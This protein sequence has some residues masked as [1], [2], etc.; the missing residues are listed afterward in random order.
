MKKTSLLT[1]LTA[2]ILAGCTPMPEKPGPLEG[3]W[4]MQHATFTWGDTTVSWQADKMHMQTK[5]FTKGY[6]A[7]VNM[8]P[9]D[10]GGIETGGGSGTYKVQGDT[11]FETLLLMPDKESL[12]RTFQ[13]TIE[14][15]GDTL[16][17]KGPINADIPASWEGFK[18]KEVYLRKE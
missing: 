11:L 10:M 6:F 3:V 9:S 15:R 12:G 17:Q 4:E 14:V 5:M 16:I 13:Y 1:A 7:F 8:G 18:L 2:M